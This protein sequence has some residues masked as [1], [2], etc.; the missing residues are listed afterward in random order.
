[1]LNLQLA[2]K[3][4]RAFFLVAQEENKLTEY[5]EELA[6]VAKAIESQADLKLF[7][8][9][10]QVRAGAKKDILGKLFQG[11]IS[12][13]TLNFLFLLADKKRESLLEEIT[14]AY[15]AF[16]NE[17]RGIIVA[18]VTSALEISPEASG[19]LQKKLAALTGKTVKVR[20]RKSVV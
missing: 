1:M 11:E 20:D 8:T 2:R 10:P 13:M 14:R 7:I 16:S 17:A 5:G 4:A 9:N 3:Y 12:E 19:R 6:A 18:D 15:E